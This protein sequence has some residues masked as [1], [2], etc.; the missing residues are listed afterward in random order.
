MSI[1]VVYNNQFFTKYITGIKIDTK[2]I[3]SIYFFIP[4]LSLNNLGIFI[5]VIEILLSIL[6]YTII[7]YKRVTCLNGNHIVHHSYIGLLKIWHISLARKYYQL[8]LRQNI[9]KYLTKKYQELI[10][11][12]SIYYTEIEVPETRPGNPTNFLKK[13]PLNWA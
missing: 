3:L 8:C 12:V 7:I 1:L 6:C 5:K 4:G 13:S 2:S 11:N 9:L 10:S